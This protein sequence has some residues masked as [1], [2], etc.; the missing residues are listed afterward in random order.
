MN[1]PSDSFSLISETVRYHEAQIIALA[2]ENKALRAQLEA[3]AGLDFDALRR[4]L[5]ALERRGE[6]DV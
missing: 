1:V 3:L 4:L 2:N 5:R 6:Y